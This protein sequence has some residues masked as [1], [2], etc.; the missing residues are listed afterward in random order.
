[1]RRITLCVE[2]QERLAKVASNER[3]GPM[4]FRQA[5]KDAGYEITNQKD[6]N[7][8]IRGFKNARPGTAVVL[9]KNQ[10]YRAVAAIRCMYSGT[11]VVSRRLIKAEFRRRRIPVSDGVLT[12]SLRAAGLPDDLQES[13]LPLTLKQMADECGCE[14]CEDAG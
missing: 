4:K 9:T 3:W 6:V 13:I 11:T 12:L 10:W 8:L 5:I 1:M 14:E 2:D 7:A